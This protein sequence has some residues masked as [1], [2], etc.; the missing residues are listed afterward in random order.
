MAQAVEAALASRAQPATVALTD[1]E[2]RVLQAMARG[3]TPKAIAQLHDR[4]LHTI[5]NQIKAL[6]RKLGAS[7]SMDAVAKAR[8]LGLLE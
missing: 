6:N 1:A 5:R 8:I 4:S 7:G 3:G 2:R